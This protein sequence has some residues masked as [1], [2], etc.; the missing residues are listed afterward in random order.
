MKGTTNLT[1]HFLIAMPGLEDSNFSRT[2]TYVCEHSDQGAMGLVVNRP[3]GLLLGE[4]FD[5][6]DIHVSDLQAARQ[7]VYHGG[8]VQ[9][10]RGF[11]L[12][13]GDHG[14]DSTVRLN[15]EISITTSQDILRAIAAGEGPPQI[16]IALGYAGWGK[17]QL[18][19]ELAQNSWLS[20]P[21]SS[22]ILFNTPYE[23]R[24][25]AAARLLGVDMDLLPTQAGHG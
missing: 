23:L 13:T 1:N 19:N 4:I 22:E 9:P 21:A 16:L 24:W 17:G 12:H 2:V 5:Q 6:L 7:P 10:D 15:D 18:E 20:A 25:H 11:V 14:Y 8:P 3:T